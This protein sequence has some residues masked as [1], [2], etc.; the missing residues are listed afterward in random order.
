MKTNFDRLFKT[1]KAKETEGIWY[2]FPDNDAAF[3]LRRF[4]GENTTLVKKAMARYYKPYAKQIDLGMLP[5]EKVT[6]IM[7]KIFVDVCLLDWKNIEVDGEDAPFSKEL[8]VKVL[9]HL[10]E[11]MDKLTALAN[12]TESFKED[13]GNY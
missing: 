9:V 11:L 1:D 12:D 13:L 7:A 5:D 2:T 3:L 10:P 4:G 8:A 6:E